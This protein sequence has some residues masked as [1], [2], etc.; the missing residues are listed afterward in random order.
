[1][2]KSNIPRKKGTLTNLVHMY[3]VSIFSNLLT[4]LEIPYMI[5]SKE[6]RVHKQIQVQSAYSIVC[7]HLLS[8]Q[9]VY[10]IIK[11]AFTFASLHWN[12]VNP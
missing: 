10:K 9:K 8:D 12:L 5:S 4:L 2:Q 3:I 1:M 6:R 7:Y 11:Y